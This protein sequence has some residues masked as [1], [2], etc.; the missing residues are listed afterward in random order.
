MVEIA[1]LKVGWNRIENNLKRCSENIH[2]E[3]GYRY[4]PDFWYPNSSRCAFTSPRSNNCPND[5]ITVNY[6]TW[7]NH[8]L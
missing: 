5:N 1:E 4:I 6:E 2:E 3:G 8:C 7:W